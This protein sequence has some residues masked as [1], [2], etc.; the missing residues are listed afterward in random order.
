MELK[1]PVLIIVTGY[2]ASGKTSLSRILCEKLPAPLFSKDAFKEKLFD[3]LGSDGRAH[4]KAL[5]WAAIEIMFEAAERVLAAG[6]VAIIESPLIAKLTNPW[7]RRMED[8]YA[9]LTIQL[10][11][12]ASSQELV[13]RFAERA[14]NGDRHP[15]HVEAEQIEELT[16]IVQTPFTPITVSGLTMRI[17][18]NDMDAVDYD[19]I[20][21]RVRDAVGLPV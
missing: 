2:P 3:I 11:M 1:Q 13:R 21:A 15:G 17:D 9:C 7:V 4:S 20:V 14:Q 10:I 6:G 18:A 12:D 8:E 16:E 5:G 19:A